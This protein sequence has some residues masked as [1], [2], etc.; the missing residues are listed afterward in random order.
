[1]K[2]VWKVLTLA[3][4]TLASSVVVLAEVDESPIDIE[5]VR[6]FPNLRIRRPVVI[7]N[8]GDQSNR[9]FIV[10]Q[11]GMI[12]LIPND[13]KVK[14]TQTFLDIEDQVVYDDR[15]NEE[16]LLGLTFH[17]NYEENG[18]FYVYYTTKPVAGYRQKP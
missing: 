9:L 14:E 13:Q 15:K 1:M 4:V 5:V 18:Y 16:G 8:A 10:T 2:K 3:I 17:P 7:T 11:Q 6:A 12:H